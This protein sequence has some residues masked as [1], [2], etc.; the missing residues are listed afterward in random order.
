MASKGHGFFR[1]DTIQSRCWAAWS[2]RS[3]RFLY[4]IML[5][6]FMAI[7]VSG[8]SGLT[9][10]GPKNAP[11]TS[12][13]SLKI[14]TNSLPSAQMQSAYQT[15]VTATGGKAPYVWSITSGALPTGLDLTT[16]TGV[17]SG[18]PLKPGNFNF[19]L[20]VMDSS[21]PLQKTTAALAISIPSA[22]GNALQITTTSLP[23]GQPSNSYST[24]LEAAG[25]TA[26]YTWSITTGSLPNGLALNGSNGI[27]SGLSTQ[28]GNFNFT[29]QAVD[30]SSPLQKATAALAINIPSGTPGTNL[31]ITTTSLPG[32]QLGSAYS[33]TLG[34]SG[35]T[36]PYTWSTTAGQLPPSVNL[37]GTSGALVGVPTQAGQFSFKVQI[38][39]SSQPAKIASRQFLVSI[40]QGQF[41]TYSGLV[42]AGCTP[43]VGTAGYFG[44]AKVNNHWWFCDPQGNAFWST[45][46]ESLDLQDGGPA[47]TAA[48]KRK[49]G[50]GTS[51]PWATWSSVSVQRLQSWGFNTIGAYANLNTFPD[52]IYGAAAG[53]STKLPYVWSIQPAA[54][55]MRDFN[56]KD[57]M[58]GTSP[59]YQGYRGRMPDLFDPNWTAEVNSQIANTFKIFGSNADNSPWLLGVGMDFVDY[60]YGWRNSQAAHN[61]W[62]VATMSPVQEWKPS[63]LEYQTVLF[64]DPVVHSKVDWSTWLQSK[65]GTIAALN[66]AWGSNYSSFGTSGSSV[67]A[68]NIGSG[69][70]STTTFTATLT[71]VVDP[72]SIQVF[73][74][75]TAVGGDCPW[76][77]TAYQ[78]AQT[79][80]CAPGGNFTG[81]IQGP[82]MSAGSINYQTGALTVTF[83][84]APSAG[85]PITIKYANNGWPKELAGGTGLLD[86]DGS[87]SWIGNDATALT[88][89]SPGAAAD[90]KAYL[91][92]FAA[93]YCSSV[94]TPLRA[95][96]PHHLIFGPGGFT[97]STRPEV[98]KACGPYIDFTYLSISEVD[99]QLAGGL[100]P[101]MAAM[102]QN[103]GKPMI[104]DTI[105][106][107]NA[108]SDMSAFPSTTA[109]DHPTQAARGQVY[110]AQL[111]MAITQQ[112]PDGVFP[113]IGFDFWEWV[114]KVGENNNYGLVTF[115]G[116]NAYDGVQDTI[117]PG[118]DPWGYPTGGESANYGDFL[119]SVTTA[120]KQWYTNPAVK[121]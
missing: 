97:G 22:P 86:E 78:S 51:F 121:P 108:D 19:T 32:G 71:T 6:A 13:T 106:T 90:M 94:A 80:Q 20:Q 55:G 101:A 52:P 12:A 46:V 85:A 24:T 68:Q 38:T 118:T 58:Y 49:Y 66:Q 95:A 42:G 33:V 69:D 29:V 44:L 109:W 21:T 63:T 53:N 47:Y 37:S 104:T 96:F 119:T 8:C 111:T 3:Y 59:V 87:S 43:T 31:Q 57:M 16:S 115:D 39:D 26:P 76:F 61:G 102:Y 17:I 98:L 114:D 48:V 11:L 79:V 103:M 89:A 62:V 4:S 83:S 2:N 14:L 15:S 23:A 18:D 100:V 41:D 92:R 82:G 88:T 25:G 117:A 70:S 113:V 54:Y 91:T 36:A 10:A 112:M 120:N 40:S 50:A 35:G 110:N 60:I 56:I 30:S 9:S 67:S 99:Q 105:V 28:S 1:I 34:V 5:G 93:Q 72:L 65:Y 107:A 75:G 7:T 74:A 64:S 116:D 77:E 45:A 81:A 27:I 73:V 84:S